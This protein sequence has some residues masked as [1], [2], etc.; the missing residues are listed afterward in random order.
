MALLNTLAKVASKPLPRTISPRVHSMIDLITAGTFIAG[1][2]LFWRRNKRAS[3]AALICGGADLAVMLLTDY[4]GGVKKTIKYGAHY[5]IDLGLATM[6]AT[7]P[8]FVAFQDEPEKRFFLLQG[9]VTTVIA[10]ITRFPE[11]RGPK[12]NRSLSREAA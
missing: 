9:A 7:M 6:F 3:V 1:A 5:G 11:V 2:G 8:E 4:P 10:E 12:E